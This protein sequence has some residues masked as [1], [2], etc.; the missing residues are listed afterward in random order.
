MKR[1]GFLIIFVLFLVLLIGSGVLAGE[2][3]VGQE[4]RMKL[5]A[6]QEEEG[7]YRGS[8][9]DLYLELN[10]GSGRVFLE[11]FPLTK[12]DTQISTRFAKEIACDYFDL[13]CSNY[14]FIYTIKAKSNIV[15][16]P[17]A[18]AA[19]AALTVVTLLDLEYDEKTT[20]TG[21]IN[22]GGIIGPVGGLKEKLEAA[23]KNDL[24]KVLIAKGTGHYKEGNKTIDLISFARNNLSLEVKE[25]SD[26]NEVVFELSGKKLKKDSRP[27]EISQNYQEIMK[28]LAGL[29][30]GRTEELEK[31]LKVFKISV[32]ESKEIEEK[33]NSSQVSL[34][35][36][37]YYSAASFCFGA[38]IIIRRLTYDKQKVG[39]GWVKYE[40]GSLA[41]KVSMLEEQLAKK[42]VK[43]ISDLQTRMI[44]KERLGEVKE[45]LGEAGKDN[46]WN[47]VLAYAEER[48]FSAFGWMYFFKM[49][50][51]EFGLDK[52]RLKNSCL[53]KISESEERYQYAEL[54]FRGFDIGYIREKVELAKGSLNLEEYELCLIKA[55]QAKAEANALLSSIGLDEEG[56][57][58]FLESKKK[59]VEKVIAENSEEGVFPILGYSYYQYANS[60]GEEKHSVLLYL[61]YALEMSDLDIYFEEEGAVGGINFRLSEG[62]KKL[63]FLGG[64]VILGS[65][66]TLT[67]FF[68]VK[69]IKKRTK[70]KNSKR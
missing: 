67:I 54:L 24:K 40:L 46:D 55:I 26:L 23:A 25:V 60:L 62:E 64:G 28:E 9:A 27:V 51:K 7:K 29:L 17:S 18:G 45:V 5:L 53:E 19:A 61:E 69:K 58:D 66:L 41:R 32:N 52:E 44:V 11:T 12:M 43:T 15:G 8:E 38:N 65:L 47:S 31:E 34:S 36:G 30:C 4:K 21:T 35:K 10:E 39:K 1:K 42:K 14:D 59:A 3:L 57:D 48:F 16:G 70:K 49:G 2:E 50:G 33:K 63:V 56:I 20:I 6:V 13:D 68:T 22:S 37:D